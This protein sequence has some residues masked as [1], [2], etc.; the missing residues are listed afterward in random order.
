MSEKKPVNT[1]K[2]L[3]KIKEQLKENYDKAFKD[4][5][6]QELNNDQFDWVCK[7]HREMV[8][9]ICSLIPNR[10]DIH[11]RIAEDMDPVIFR[12][13][14][15]NKAFNFESLGNLINYVFGWIKKLCSPFRDPE[16]QSSVEGIYKMAQEGGTIGKIVPHFIF[17]V[18]H[19]IDNI[20]KDM[21]GST[22]Q[23]FKKFAE[24]KKAR[25]TKK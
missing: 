15:E 17:E 6:E 7:L 16:I 8:I 12:Q 22:A 2:S 9:R 18:H 20:E 3:E 19:H 11:N 21:K 14:L 24:A 25:F 5:L 4:A 10:P 13:M 23:D 1:E